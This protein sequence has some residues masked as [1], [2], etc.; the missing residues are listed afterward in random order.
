[1]VVTGERLCWRAVLVALALR[2][3]QST[4]QTVLNESNRAGA[5]EQRKSE[6]KALFYTRP[7]QLRHRP[8]IPSQ[9]PPTTAGSNAPTYFT[10]AI[11]HLHVVAR[12]GNYY[13]NFIFYRPPFRYAVFLCREKRGSFGKNRFTIKKRQP[14][15]LLCTTPSQN[16]IYFLIIIAELL[17]MSTLQNGYSKCL[18]SRLQMPKFGSIMNVKNSSQGK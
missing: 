14:E 7:T 4:A 2:V 11:F 13:R 15:R 6:Q 9:T 8:F 18:S 5:A 12:A 10:C 16:R 1:M 17:L 3:N